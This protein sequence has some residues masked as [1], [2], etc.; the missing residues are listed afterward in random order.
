MYSATMSREKKN[1][2]VKIFHNFIVPRRRHLL[3]VSLIY[4][5]NIMRENVRDVNDA[6]AVFELFWLISIMFYRG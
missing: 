2:I 5:Y 1:Y 6:T 3:T 4:R